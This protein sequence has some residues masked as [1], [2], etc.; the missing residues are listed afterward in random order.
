MLVTRPVL[1]RN[2]LFRFIDSSISEVGD[3]EGSEQTPSLNLLA[4]SLQPSGWIGNVRR[5]VPED[6]GAAM[7]HLD[8]DEINLYVEH[9]KVVRDETVIAG[10][11]PLL[12]TLRA[13]K[14]V[15]DRNEPTVAGVL[16]YGHDPQASFPH[17]CVQAARFKGTSTDIFLDRV[18]IMGTIRHQ[19]EEAMRFVRRNI[20][21][22][23]QVDG[24]R[25]HDQ[26]EYPMVAVREIV[27]NALVH[28]D[29]SISGQ[30]V[31]LAIF[32]DCI[33]VTSP[34][35]LSES[36]V[37][38]FRRVPFCLHTPQSIAYSLFKMFSLV[39]QDICPLRRTIL[40]EVRRHAEIGHP[41]VRT[42][43]RPSKREANF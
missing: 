7:E 5:I 12:R 6:I 23:G 20:R 19:L 10:K 9:R 15:E 16:L 18:E 35:H 41:S 3:A 30:T 29:Y 27:A 1:C 21:L 17:A 37:R 42:V 43:S 28:R 14:S 26:Y 13:V 32:D 11:L 33:E 2:S 31:R 40:R 34:A 4:V 36:P 8:S 22:N 39:G 25:R 38:K 24:V